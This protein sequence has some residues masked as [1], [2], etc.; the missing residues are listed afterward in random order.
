[1]LLRWLRRRWE[2]A[3]LANA[4]ASGEASARSAE[5]MLEIDKFRLNET[6]LHGRRAAAAR[7]QG[8]S[9]SAGHATVE[10]VCLASHR[11]RAGAKD[12]NHLPPGALSAFTI[13]ENERWNVLD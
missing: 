5:T 6:M 3:R 11:E 12:R 10:V 2:V 1:M 13:H 7:T 9:R 8:A 4:G